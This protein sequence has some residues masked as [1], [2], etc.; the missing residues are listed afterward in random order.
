M[1]ALSYL[2]FYSGIGGWG[3]ALEHACRSL[4]HATLAVMMDQTH[5]LKKPKLM[6]ETIEKA[7]TSSQPFQIDAKLLAAYD[8]SELCNSVFMH[9]HVTFTTPAQSS[10]ESFRYKPRQTPIERITKE[11]LE[12]H[13]ATIWCMSPPCQ[14]HTRQHSNQQK[15]MDDPR[16]KS[17]LHLCHLLSVMDDDTLPSLILLENVVGFERLWEDNSLGVDTAVAASSEAPTDS[18]VKRSHTLKSQKGSTSRGSFAEWRRVLSYRQYDVAHF[19]LDPTNVG[20]PNNRPRYYCIA[21]RRG[22]LR[23]Q[24]NKEEFTKHPLRSVLNTRILNNLFSREVL[25]K[26]PII[27]DENS[28]NNQALNKSDNY[29]N[30]K[31]TIP[32]INFFLDADLMKAISHS[33]QELTAKRLSLQIPQKVQMSSSSW[34]FDIVTPLHVCS[35][36]FTHSYGKYIRGTGSIL[37]AGPLRLGTENDNGKVIEYNVPSIE[38]FQLT[39]PEERS[40]DESWSNG[41]NWDHMRY[42]SGTEIARLM[43]FPVLEPAAEQEQVAY[44]AKEDDLMIRKFSFPST[45]SM[46][47]QWKL[48]GNSLNVRVAARIAAIGIQ[49]ILNDLIE[50][51]S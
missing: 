46:K 30:E 31:T 44:N 22:G 33:S 11:E 27:L 34:C 47:Q 39:L 32:P 7:S 10:N 50:D 41:I 19:H 8:H 14:P 48:L 37:Y 18:Q 24:F 6:S 49:A 15:E 16:S 43:G 21:F 29:K 1:I 4:Q 28:I 5:L 40:Y 42:L 2:E 45:C 25:D 20:I 51:K 3:Y 35:S 26:Q 38:R 9:N 12:S 23:R 17:F 36:C 13:S